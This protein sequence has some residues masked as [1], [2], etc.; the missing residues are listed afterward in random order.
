MNVGT[1]LL[2]ILVLIL[3]GVVPVWPH[4][5]AWGYWPGGVVGLVLVVVVV[6]ILAG[7]L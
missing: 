3:I 5:Q 2:I 7:R 6:L 1:L 4:A